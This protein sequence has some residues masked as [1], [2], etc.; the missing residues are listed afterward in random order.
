MSDASVS[1]AYPLDNVLG[2]DSDRGTV[3]E[4]QTGLFAL[5][6]NRAKGSGTAEPIAD[7]LLTLE[8][9]ARAMA[10]HT[11][12]DAFDPALHPQDAMHKREYDRDMAARV[13]A[14]NGEAHAVANLRDAE[15]KLA[16]TP[17]AGAKP[18]ANRWL[19]A[20][21]VSTIAITCAPTIHDV[22][23][24]NLGDD[25]LAW[26]FS[27]L[28]AGL[29]AIMV[30]LAIISGR[31]TS[32]TWIG[33][34]AGIA[35][36][37]GLGALRLSS[38]DGAAEVLLAV[39]FTIVEV[40]AV[41]L[42]EW[43]ASGLRNSEHRWEQFKVVEDEAV[44]AHA[45]AQTDLSRWEARVKDLDAKVN[46]RIA[47]VEDRHNRNIHLPELEAVAVKAVR[48]G[49]SAGIAENL[50]RLRAVGRRV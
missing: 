44:N 15:T 42:L 5:G 21:F 13:E 27:L 46:R 7:D 1:S 16:K 43:L 18:M 40:A 11:Y 39:G 29:L 30:T 45:A 2:A 24:H 23:F 4:M 34:A 32:L 3:L 36:G 33:V 35:L 19:L 12:R 26:F 37:I 50:G 41:L 38:A 14:E 49:Y 47:M 8:D 20:G 6:Y 17:R 25:G 31:R 48:D 9:H 10:R 28:C 22:L